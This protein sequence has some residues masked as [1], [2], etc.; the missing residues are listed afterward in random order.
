MRFPQ[1]LVPTKHYAQ[2]L[3]IQL[4]LRAEMRKKLQ[5]RHPFSILLGEK[6]ITLNR[7]ARAKVVTHPGYSAG[8]VERGGVSTQ[9]TAK[10][11]LLDHHHAHIET[12]T[13][14]DFARVPGMQVV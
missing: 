2:S 4:N 6:T 11:R 5:F 9:C 7:H 8:R 13:L 10:K 14:A 1:Q 3:A 12:T